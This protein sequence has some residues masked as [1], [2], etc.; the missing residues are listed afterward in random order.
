[1]HYHMEV[2]AAD[3]F[4]ALVRAAHAAKPAGEPANTPARPEAEA[5]FSAMFEKTLPLA[6][7][8][9]TLTQESIKLLGF[10]D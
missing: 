3:D 5:V 6:E 8:G 9:E 2:N 7:A 1:M 4:D 10:S